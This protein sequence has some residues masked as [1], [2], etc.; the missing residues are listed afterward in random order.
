MSQKIQYDGDPTIFDPLIRDGYDFRLGDYIS[1]GWEIFRAYPGGF[2]AY[3][4]LLAVITIVVIFIPILGPLA[5]FVISPSLAAGYYLVAD[6]I[7]HDEPVEFGSFFDGFNYLGQ[8]VLVGLVGGILVGI[9]TLFFILPGIYLAVAY[10]FAAP[11]V[12]FARL[13][14]WPALETSR[15]VI[16]KNWFSIFAFL[17]VLGFLINLGFLVFGLGILIA[18][19]VYYLAMYSAYQDI[20]GIMD[21]SAYFDDRIDEIGADEG[22]SDMGSQPF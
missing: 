6:R 12:L 20:F 10:S 2:V 16:S 5:F 11:L 4:L 22:Q 15:K 3:T 8:L 9:A 14:F 21:E 17:I 1:R 19:P 18:L 13:E 7:V